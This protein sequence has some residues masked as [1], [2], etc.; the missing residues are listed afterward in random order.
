MLKSDHK[1]FFYKNELEDLL[2]KISNE[3]RCKCLFPMPLGAIN[4]PLWLK[5]PILLLYKSKIIK[6]DI[7]YQ[8]NGIVRCKS[9]DFNQ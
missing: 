6:F 2:S 3:F 5:Y 4:L 8:L 9:S 7:F 1:N